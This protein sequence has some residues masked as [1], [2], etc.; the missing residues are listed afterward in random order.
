MARNRTI[1]VLPST[2]QPS[3]AEVKEEFKINA[4]PEKLA[5]AILKPVEIKTRDVAE[6]RAR[7]RSH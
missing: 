7:K 2:Y 1:E 6:Y 4:T 5:K 3:R